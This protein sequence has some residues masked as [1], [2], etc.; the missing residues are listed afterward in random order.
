MFVRISTILLALGVSLPL[1]AQSSANQSST[2]SSS[3]TSSSTTVVVPPRY[4]VEAIGISTRAMPPMASQWQSV[5]PMACPAV[6]VALAF[7]EA[8]GPPN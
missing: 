7:R 8:V 2:T 1:L 3:S 4:F 5:V 6:Q